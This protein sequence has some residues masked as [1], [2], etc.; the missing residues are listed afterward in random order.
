VAAA[1]PVYGRS[2]SGTWSM[3][4][5]LPDGDY[6]LLL[7]INKEFDNNASHAYPSY[8]DPR[9]PDAG[10]TNNFGQ[11]AVVFRVPI[12]L[13]RSAPRQ[14]VATDIAGYA[15][16]DGATGQLHPADTTIS[17]KPGSGR[18]RLLLISQPSIDGGAPLVG[19]VHVQTEVDQTPRCHPSLI[20]K[21]EVS[22][23]EIPTA[24]VTATQAT[25]QFVEP[26]DGDKTVEQYD[27]RYRQGETMTEEEFISA[28]PAPTVSPEAPGSIR[29]FT[30]LG[31]RPITPYVV[32]IR[33]TGGCLQKG[34]LA[35]RS[36]VTPQL[37]FKQLSGCFIATA[38][39]GSAQ[40][41]RLDRLRGLR[42]AARPRSSLAAAAVDAYERS[43]P[44]VAAVLRESEVARAVVRGLLAPLIDVLDAAR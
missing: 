16:W 30:L 13:D 4:A 3:P 29:S 25:V 2:Y 6:A 20:G 34:P 10:F 11:P 17:D 1:T 40:E 33:A 5:G 44:P 15:D 8:M 18:G 7:E 41:P 27:I 31:L 14:A 9:L 38:A 43:S 24:T 32:G 28:I 21:G 35:R 19:R 37:E 22:S 39:Y 12:R 36:F 26:Y 23:L 42:D